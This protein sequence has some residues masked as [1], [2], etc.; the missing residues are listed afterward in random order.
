MMTALLLFGGVFKTNCSA[1]PHMPGTLLMWCVVCARIGPTSISINN[2]TL[3]P[4]RV[5]TLSVTSVRL[6]QQTHSPSRL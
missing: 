5:W 6:G 4:I 2:N 3:P 1:L